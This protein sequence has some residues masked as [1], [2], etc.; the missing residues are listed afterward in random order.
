M[1]VNRELFVL[2]LNEP[3]SE[4]TTHVYNKLLPQGNLEMNKSLTLQFKI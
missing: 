2:D 4:M 3:G 1:G